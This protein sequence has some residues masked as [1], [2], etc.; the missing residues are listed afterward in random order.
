MECRR[1]RY[2]GMGWGVVEQDVEGQGAEDLVVVA[3]S[4]IQAVSSQDQDQANR[5][6]LHLAYTLSV[7][8]VDDFERVRKE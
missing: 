2:R 3:V 8:D 7:R 5:S 6:R 4:N 1:I